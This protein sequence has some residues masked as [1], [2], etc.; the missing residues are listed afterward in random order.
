MPHVFV[1][2]IDTA[3][4]TLG[5][6]PDPEARV[7]EL[8]RATGLTLRVEPSR[9]VEQPEMAVF[10]LG[11]APQ[12]ARKP[13]STPGFLAKLITGLGQIIAIDQSLPNSSRTTQAID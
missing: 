7:E 13:A 8:S 10:V 12:T 6:A 3:L 1:A 5:L 9:H 2:V 4:V 11:R